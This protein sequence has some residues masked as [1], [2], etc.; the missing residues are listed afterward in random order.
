LLWRQ[1]GQLLSK[2]FIILENGQAVARWRFGK[3]G[4]EKCWL[5]ISQG[6]TTGKQALFIE[7]RPKLAVGGQ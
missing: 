6:L 7:K 3:T 5:I 1:T 4:G 2:K